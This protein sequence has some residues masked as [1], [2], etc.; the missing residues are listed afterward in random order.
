MTNYEDMH[1]RAALGEP[2]DVARE[3]RF[4]SSVA[5]LGIACE[6]CHGPGERHVELAQS[7]WLRTAMRLAPG[8]DQSIINPVRL[9]S[10]K[11]SHVCA[12]CHA[13]RMV[14]DAESLRSMMH[15]G[16]SFRPGE[17]LY[18]HVEPVT[19][20]AVAPVRGREDMFELRFWAD[21][22]PRLTA[23]EYQGM[24]LSAC[25][26]RAEMSC[27]DCHSMHAGDPAG[28]I[29]DRNRGNAPCLR[30]HQE[31]RR[32]TAL[33]AHT[34]HEADSAGSLCYSCHMPYLKYGVMDI[35]R[36]HR[37]E[38]P[39]ARRDAE[40][41]RPNA[42][43]QCHLEQSPGWAAA[44][45]AGWNKG[46]PQAHANA[47]WVRQDGGPA[48]LSDLSTVL[49]GDPVQKAVAAW[50]AGQDTQFQ[51]GR[52][53]AWM[54]AYLIAAL[55]DIYPSTRRFA[56]RSLHAILL[57]WPQPE[58]VAELRYALDDFDF[59]VE[60]RRRERPMQA[61]RNA[62]KALDKSDWP[63]PPPQSGVGS[64]FLLPASLRDELVELGRRQD[65]QISIGE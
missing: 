36:S 48:D 4:E 10:E 8:R 3:A 6:T 55:D 45:L 30:C 54:I 58:E 32:D 50:W 44:E 17:N 62:W 47:D 26:E 42:C 21:G 60:H 19:R 46:S 39:D 53:R 51:R 27:M 38:I 11:A 57:D 31:F 37:I 24:H 14:P 9:G 18:A 2:V 64:D 15:S 29:T 20:D 65:K 28:Q 52:D 23:Y 22:T 7:G 25:Y 63:A 56:G 41:G 12:Q 35:H 16:P 43:L 59:M 1:T 49:V 61:L 33:E 13:Q 34:A 40:T 5:E